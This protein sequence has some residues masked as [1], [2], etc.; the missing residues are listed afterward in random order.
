MSHYLHYG[1]RFFFIPP[2]VY[3]VQDEF[4]YLKVDFFYARDMFPGNSVND[5]FSALYRQRIETNLYNN[6]ND[7]DD[8][9]DDDDDYNKYVS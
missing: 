4:C 8:D 7:D 5:C 2:V 3:S 6:N 1:I 9:D